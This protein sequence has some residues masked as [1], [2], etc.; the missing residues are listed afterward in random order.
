MDVLVVVIGRHDA[1]DNLLCSTEEVKSLEHVG[2]VV[3]E[4][5]PLGP[6]PPDFR[7]VLVHQEIT[8]TADNNIVGSTYPANLRQLL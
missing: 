2:D 6:W 8:V 7:D 1:E 4:E 5:T 3:L